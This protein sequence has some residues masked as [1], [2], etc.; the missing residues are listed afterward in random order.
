MNCL[1]TRCMIVAKMNDTSTGSLFKWQ[2][3]HSCTFWHMTK[4]SWCVEVKMLIVV[5][6]PCSL[7]LTSLSSTLQTEAAC[8][9]IV[10]L[11]AY[12][13]RAL[14]SSQGSFLHSPVTSSLLCPN[15]FLST[16]FSY[17]FSLCS[18]LSVSDQVSHPHKTTG[19]INVSPWISGWVT[20]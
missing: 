3:I 1:A 9:P 5:V 15:V 13:T 6:T 18:S 7:A 11:S 10:L 16:L 12:Q 20:E 2:R 14:S 17:T 19:K 8:C 4:C